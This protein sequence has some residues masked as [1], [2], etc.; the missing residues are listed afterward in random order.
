[1][2]DVA[3]LSDDQLLDVVEGHASEDV[4]A[5]AD[6]CAQCAERVA[7]LRLVLVRL[8]DDP[9]PEPDPWFWARLS[10]RVDAA[11]KAD[12][13]QRR[14]GWRTRWNWKP[15]AVLAMA[16][17]GLVVAVLLLGP[18]ED[19]GR[20]TPE[21]AP[22]APAAAVAEFASPLLADDAAFELIAAIV[23]RGS[24][25]DSDGES[26]VLAPGAVDQAAWHLS[27]DEQDALVRLLEEELAG[28]PS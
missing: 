15:A 14:A 9:A 18:S 19:L 26:F 24:V 22:E 4:R 16:A 3:H 8:A 6:S 25:G 5:H 10:D 27:A 7:P 12:A 1:M 21:R 28:R 23:G 11:V 20:S 17:A 13:T 2:K